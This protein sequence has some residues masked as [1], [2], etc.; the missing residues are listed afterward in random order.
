MNINSL[1]KNYDR[2]TMLQRLVLADN[3]LGRNDDNEALAIK[4]AS[5]RISY[6]QTDFAELL[7]DIVNIRL[8]NLILRFG[9]I[10][11]YEMFL[12]PDLEILKNKSVGKPIK[13]RSGAIRLSAYLYVRATDSWQIVND[14]L[15][16][17]SNFDEEFAKHLFP[18]ELLMLKDE[19]MRDVAFSEEEARAYL[20]SKCGTEDLQTIEDEV[21][22]YRKMLGLDNL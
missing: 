11:S 10:L 21:T 17:R 22:A 12:R 20:M 13:D 14:E 4:N 5:P 16:L 18:I 9:Y 1:R 7:N 3:A 6:T 19:A 15:G 8:C 2:L